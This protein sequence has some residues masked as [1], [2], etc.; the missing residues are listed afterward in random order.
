MGRTRRSRAILARTLREANQEPLLSRRAWVEAER[1]R[2]H[3]RSSRVGAAS[4]VAAL[5]I[6]QR[7]LIKGTDKT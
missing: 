3:G 7:G 5:S 1:S 6:S 4:I 2:A